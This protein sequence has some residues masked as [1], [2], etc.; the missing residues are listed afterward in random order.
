VGQ[1][2]NRWLQIYAA[3]NTTLW[4]QEGYRGNIERYI[5]PAIGRIELQKLTPDQIQNMYAELL[6]RPLSNRTIR[7]AH[8][9]F[10]EALKHAVKWGLLT[11]NPA[12]AIT[13]P[14]AEQK[15]LEM[16]DVET[17]QQFLEAVTG[18]RFRDFYHLA[19]LT[20]MRRSEL[21]GLKWE[22][23]DLISGRLS[24]VRTLQRIAGTGLMEG[25]PKTA[26]SRRSIALSPQAVKLLHAIR[27]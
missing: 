12:D 5:I 9:V 14:R 2:L 1:F 11:R 22:D 10:S 6:A 19:L 15:E 23:V 16:W 24:V 7:H 20:G 26:R 13:P 17:T 21:C 25:Q 4:T 27:G 8:R 18:H 3:S